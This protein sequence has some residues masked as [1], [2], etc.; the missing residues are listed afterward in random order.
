MPVALNPASVLKKEKHE[1]LLF[2]AVLHI[3]HTDVVFT[4]LFTIQE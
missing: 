2:F 3:L 1:P 4:A